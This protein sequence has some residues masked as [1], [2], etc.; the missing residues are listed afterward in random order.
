MSTVP[1]CTRAASVA[2]HVHDRRRRRRRDAR[3]DADRQAATATDGAGAA[4][5]RT[6]PVHPLGQRVE[7]GV[8]LHAGH[9]R[10]GRVRTRPSRRALRRRNSSGSIAE[11]AGDDVGLALVGPDELRDAEAAQ[12]ARGR[13][14]GVDGVVVQRHVLDVVRAGGGEAGLLR[15]ARADVR[16]GAAVPEGLDLARDHAAVV[17]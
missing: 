13:L 4:I 9:D 10:A 6:V 8:D 12:R 15:D 14:V 5:E 1:Q 3:L 2:V 11:R 16:V 7:H 17:R